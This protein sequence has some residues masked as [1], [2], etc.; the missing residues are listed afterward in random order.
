MANT[1]VSG[2][3]PQQVT[4]LV[5]RINNLKKQIA[6]NLCSVSGHVSTDIR[7]NYQGQAATALLDKIRSQIPQLQEGL[8]ELESSMVTNINDDLDDTQRTDQSMA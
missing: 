7:N 5:E 4:Q 3:D 1:V 2:I 8:N 6:Q